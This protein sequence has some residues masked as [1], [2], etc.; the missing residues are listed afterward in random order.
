MKFLFS[1]LCLTLCL[2]TAGSCLWGQSAAS[3]FQKAPPAQ[4]EALRK[5]IGVFYQAHVDGKTRQA[6]SLVAEESA[7][8]FFEM[9]KPKF[10][11]FEIQQIAYG[12]EF[13]QATVMVLAERE[14]AVPF[15]GVQVMKIPLESY[16]KQVAGQW[17][18]Y[19]PKRDCKD[20]PF[21]CVPTTGPA[22][23]AGS[24]ARIKE[25]ITQIQAGQFGG[26][27][28][29]EK[30][31]LPLTNGGEAEAVFKNGMDG[32]VTLKYLNPFED[33][34]IEVIGGEQL[35][36][37]NSTG[38]VTVRVKKNVKIAK[39]REVVIPIMAQPFGRPA[40]LRVMLTP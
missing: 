33:A 19:I 22:A 4:D 25:K 34:E 12:K 11:S 37:P 7:D 35:V 18:W 21:G 26:E 36:K 1:V 3:V 30:A 15:G 9:Q 31:L 20:T 39:S 24:A 27:I 40:H 8:T 16:W 38:K 10:L 23:D 5:N 17:R 6:M 13:Q 32:Y 28:G 29:F 14:V 2:T